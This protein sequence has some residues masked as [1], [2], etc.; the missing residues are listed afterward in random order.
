MTDMETIFKNYTDI[1][2]NKDGFTIK[3][4]NSKHAMEAYKGLTETLKEIDRAS[5]KIQEKE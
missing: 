3:F 1:Q 4:D 2:L 5:E